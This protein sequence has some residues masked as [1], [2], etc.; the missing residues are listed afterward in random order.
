M[1]SRIKRSYGEIFFDTFNVVFMIV[2]CLIMVYPFWYV[3]L[4]SLN[5]GADAALGP[6]W[7]WPREFTL[8]NYAYVFGYSGLRNA[9]LVTIARCVTGPVFNIAICL[10]AAFGLSKSFLPFR[11]AI[12]LFLLGPMFIPGTMVANYLVMAKLQLI[13]NF[14]IFV[15]PGAFGYFTAVI[16]R[17]FIYSL[18]IELQESAKMDGA[19]YGTIYLRI[20]VPLCKP[21][22]A[23]F[24]FFAVVGSWMDLG[25]NLLY[26]TKKSLYTMQYFMY[27]AISSSEANNIIIDPNSRDAA[28]QI[29]DLNSRGNSLP[30]PQV[31]KMAILVVVTAPVLFIYPFFQKYFIKGMLTGSVKA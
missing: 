7:I 8:E 27:L 14:L 17:S 18:P 28:R 20:I 12:T 19:K 13:N 3:L 15:I 1:S 4:L 5:T 2:M 30:T 23:A 25:T 11:K 22:I 24:L 21:V 10:M 29:A 6:I 26:I 16:M 31:I 9:L